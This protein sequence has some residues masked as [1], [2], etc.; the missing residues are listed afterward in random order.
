MIIYHLILNLCSRSDG[1]YQSGMENIGMTVICVIM[2]RQY[3]SFI[4]F[5]ILF[6]TD[7][8]MKKDIP[9]YGS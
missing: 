1:T 7:H 4:D 8:K 5:H 2:N 3:L 9:F 6:D